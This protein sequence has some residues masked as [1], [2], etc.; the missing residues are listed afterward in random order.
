M[1]VALEYLQSTTLVLVDLDM[2]VASAA[3][4]GMQHGCNDWY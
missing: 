2:Y 3:A 1:S 4:S